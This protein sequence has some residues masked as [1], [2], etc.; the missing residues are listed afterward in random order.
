MSR[1]RV[2]HLLGIPHGELGC[3][4][5]TCRACLL[6]GRRVP[7]IAREVVDGWEPGDDMAPL[8]PVQGVQRLLL[9]EEQA[10][11]VCLTG[12]GTLRDNI[13]A[14]VERGLMLQTVHDGK[15]SIGR[16]PGD[17]ELWRVPAC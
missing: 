7:E 4:E 8:V 3:Y 1:R 6:F 15:S 5:L 14:V 12:R 2:M 9:G 13:A 17:A 10:G 16:I 11:D